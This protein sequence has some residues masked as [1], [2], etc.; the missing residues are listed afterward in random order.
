MIVTRLSCIFLRIVK[1][2]SK[3]RFQLGFGNV[4]IAP[5]G[6][7]CFTYLNVIYLRRSVRDV[8]VLK[9][10]PKWAENESNLCPLLSGRRR[11]EK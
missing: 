6:F 7:I 5:I 1:R 3:H 8:V 11:L 10:C 2:S 4:L 9:V